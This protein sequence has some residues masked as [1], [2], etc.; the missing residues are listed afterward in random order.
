MG[1]FSPPPLSGSVREKLVEYPSPSVTANIRTAR[2]L[3][4]FLLPS[5]PLMDADGDAPG[6]HR[7]DA[8][9]FSEEYFFGIGVGV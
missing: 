5:L 8:S 1:L 7:A 4:G 9:F 6:D 2:A 3:G